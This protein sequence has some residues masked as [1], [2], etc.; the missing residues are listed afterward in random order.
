MNKTPNVLQ[1]TT[2]VLICGCLAAARPLPAWADTHDASAPIHSIDGTGIAPSPRGVVETLQGTLLAYMQQA[3][4]SAEHGPSVAE[5]VS[6]LTSAVESTHDFPY[7][8]RIVLGRSWRTLDAAD[9]ARFTERFTTLSLDTYAKR[10]ADFSGEAFTITG[11]DDGNF[12]QRKITAELATREK[13][14]SFEYLLRQ[15]GDQW[16]IVN[17]IVD[18]V[19]DLALKRAEYASLIDEGGFEALL[20]ELDRQRAALEPEALREL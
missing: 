20:E 6:A 8:A 19:S 13:R 16:R 3:Q 10:F 4:S 9:Q 1:L 12:G 7:I 5:T 15:S 14:H 2:M 17:I 18:G 11:E